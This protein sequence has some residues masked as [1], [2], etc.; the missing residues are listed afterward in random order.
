MPSLCPALSTPLRHHLV[1]V[2]SSIFDIVPVAVGSQ[3]GARSL[4]LFRVIRVLRIMRE[5]A[6]LS[7]TRVGRPRGPR[8]QVWHRYSGYR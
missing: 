6:L 7:P 2:A 3:D 8:V 5:N 1:A 4:T